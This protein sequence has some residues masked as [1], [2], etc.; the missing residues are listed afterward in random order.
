MRELEGALVLGPRLVGTA[1][2]AEQVGAR[3]VEVLVAVEVEPVDEGKPRFRPRRL[4]HGDRA[5]Q[6]HDGEPVSRTSSP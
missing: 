5:V 1:E 6:L 2:A 4:G 3:R